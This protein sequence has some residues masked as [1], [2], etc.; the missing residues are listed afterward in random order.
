MA[1]AQNIQLRNPIGGKRPGFIAFLPVYKPGTLH[2]SIV[3][4]RRNFEGVTAGAFQTATVFNAILAQAV[5]PPSVDLFIYPQIMI[6][7]LLRFI[8][9]SSV[10]QTR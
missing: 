5:L 2:D 1:T 8:R 9:A 4:R 7:M 3:S 10:V 6:R